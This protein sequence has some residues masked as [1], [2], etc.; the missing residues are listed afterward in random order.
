[1]QIKT[2]LYQATINLGDYS[3]EKIGFTAEVQ[4]DENIEDVI[5]SLKAKVKS[6]GGLNADEFYAKQSDGKRALRELEIKI[7]KAK[8]Q[9]DATA[10]FLRT[11]GIKPDSP[12]MPAFTNLLPEVKE[13]SSGVV[14]GELEVDRIAF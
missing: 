3:N 8:E 14:D 12:N 13:E 2:V 7:R 11:Q 1:M 6:A 4:E 9:W 5:E 10:E